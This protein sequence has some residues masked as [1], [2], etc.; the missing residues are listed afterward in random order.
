L[1][2]IALNWASVAPDA[3]ALSHPARV[4]LEAISRAAHAHPEPCRLSRFDATWWCL[5]T[6]LD[7]AALQT[8][9][10]RTQ[11]LR[12]TD[13]WDDDNS[14][15]FTVGGASLESLG[16]VDTVHSTRTLIWH[17]VRP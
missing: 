10:D 13:P 11:P 6:R 3:V 2:L 8:L 16:I 7:T 12:R 15:H 9:V 5:T 17:E 4:A 14:A 1:A